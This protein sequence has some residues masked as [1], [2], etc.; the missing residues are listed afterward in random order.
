MPLVEI[1][2]FTCTNKT[3]N[4]AFAFTRKEEVVHYT[5][6]MQKLLYL[7][8]EAGVMPT[9]IMT[10]RDLALI[11]AIHIV[12][13][14]TVKH[15]LCWVHINRNIEAYANPI[16]KD[17]KAVETFCGQCWGLF[18]SVTEESY[19]ERLEKLKSSKK[20][21]LVRYVVKVWLNPY[22]ENI[23]RAWTDHHLHF[24][25]RTSNRYLIYNVYN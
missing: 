7:C 17:K 4:I 15:L 22:K 24:V 5:F 9:A 13:P 10:D 18:C 19:N 6:I 11:N 16:L 20:K 21:G 25:T 12:F 3:F 8:N 14:P 2:G 1:V 23:V